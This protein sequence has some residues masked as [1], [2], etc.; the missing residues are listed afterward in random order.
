MITQACFIIE[1]KEI[2]DA[3]EQEELMA[4]SQVFLDLEQR[5]IYTAKKQTADLLVLRLLNRLF[6]EIAPDLKLKVQDLSLA[7]VE[8][9][10]EALLDFSTVDDLVEWL[11]T[12][13]E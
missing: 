1:V 6:G 10:G 5:T 9:L 3:Q 7:Q 2:L 12:F 4:L 8:S 11:R 13:G